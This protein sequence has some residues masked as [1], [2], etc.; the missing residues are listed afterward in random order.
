MRVKCT[1]CLAVLSSSWRHGVHRFPVSQCAVVGRK[2][3]LLILLPA[4]VTFH[5]RGSI[6]HAPYGCSGRPR[7]CHGDSGR[8]LLV[9]VVRWSHSRAVSCADHWHTSNEN[10]THLRLIK[11]AATS[12][13]SNQRPHSS[14]ELNWLWVRTFIKLNAHSTLSLTSDVESALYYS[15]VV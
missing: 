12:W 11:F 1:T 4:D 3:L 8:H 15:P 10:T 14:P 5:R 13:M 2:R 9:S 6:T 7:R